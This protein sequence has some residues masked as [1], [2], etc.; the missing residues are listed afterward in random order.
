MELLP[1]GS[2]T[3]PVWDSWSGF[4][5]LIPPRMTLLSVL[6]H[7]ICM[8]EAI[9]GASGWLLLWN[10]CL[11]KSLPAPA[12]TRAGARVGHEWSESLA[13]F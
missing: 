9:L 1:V 5:P 2:Q 10:L 3:C 13:Y 6:N 4:V 11:S 7:H 8:V 12:G